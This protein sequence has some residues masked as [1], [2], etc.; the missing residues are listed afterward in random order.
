MWHG[1]RVPAPCRQKC[2][3]AV[4]SHDG[5]DLTPWGTAVG[6]YRCGL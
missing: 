1:G 4:V 3:P 2:Y 5:R 6:T